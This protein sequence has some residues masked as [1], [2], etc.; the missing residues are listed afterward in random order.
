M[1]VLKRRGA[2][3]TQGAALRLDKK[4]RTRQGSLPGER[5][6]PG[7]KGIPNKRTLLRLAAL[8]DAIKGDGILPLD[9][10]LR[11]MRTKAPQ[12]LDGRDRAAF[13]SM[14]LDAA[15][16][17]APY[18]HARK[19]DNPPKDPSDVTQDIRQTLRLMSKTTIPG[20]K[21]HA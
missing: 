7:R 13:L 16:A 19:A 14:Q 8:E 20:A 2:A 4:R 12:G 15:K 18:C 17:A 6:G 21:S 10:M 5:R 3:K 9:F 1:A 11:L